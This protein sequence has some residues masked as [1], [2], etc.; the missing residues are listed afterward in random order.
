ME[1][2]DHSDYE[3]SINFI[4]VLLCGCRLYLDQRYFDSI[5]LRLEKQTLDGD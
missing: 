2:C 5:P 3:T 4:S 1:L